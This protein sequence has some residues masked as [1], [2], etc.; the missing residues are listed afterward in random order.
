M[1]WAGKLK[2]QQHAPCMVARIASIRGATGFHFGVD[3][4]DT[5]K[6]Y[7]QADQFQQTPQC[8]GPFGPNSTYCDTVL[9]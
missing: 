4:P 1:T 9:K 5:I 2:S 6:D 3:F 8:G 7:K